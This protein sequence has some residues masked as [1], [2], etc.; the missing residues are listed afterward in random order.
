MG[1]VADEQPD[2]EPLWKAMLHF[3][4]NG[5]GR[6]A[7][8]EITDYFTFPFRP[9]LPV[10]HPGFGLPLPTDAARRKERQGEV[11]GWIDKN[12]DDFWSHDE[13]VANTSFRRDKPKLVA[14]RPGGR[15]DVT[16]SHVA[17]ELNRSIPEIPSPLFHDDRL[18]LVRNGGILT[19]VNAVDGKISYDERLGAAGQYTAS[20]V[21][22]RDHLFLVSNLG[23][24]SVVKTGDT[25]QKVHQHDLQEPAFVTPAFDGATTYIRSENY[26][27]AFRAQ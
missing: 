25:F 11:F 16:D 15:G 3:D 23:V 21:G 19:V 12:R 1:G 17:W 8:G 9:E 27:W 2:P 13:F 22:T 18:Y 20:P 7:R 14:I 10:E 5:D 26:L 6:I 24:V 4:A